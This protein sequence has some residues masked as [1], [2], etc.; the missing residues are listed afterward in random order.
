VQKCVSVRG[1]AEASVEQDFA[2]GGLNAGTGIGAHDSSFC[3][4]WGLA[5]GAGRSGI[6]INASSH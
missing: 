6:H 1:G 2:T 4:I 3:L 5:G